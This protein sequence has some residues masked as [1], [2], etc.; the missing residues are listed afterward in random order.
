MS[1]VLRYR[2]AAV[3]ILLISLQTSILA[4]GLFHNNR[5]VE[6]QTNRQER[7]SLRAERQLVA[8]AQS[9]ADAIA[10]MQRLTSELKASIER[11][12]RQI[13][14]ADLNRARTMLLDAV[15]D[16]QRR[17]PREFDRAAANDWSTTFR[18]AELQSA[19]RSANAPNTLEIVSAVQS[20]FYSDKEGV[21][22]E[23]FS[24][25][26]TGLRRYQTV[27]RL[28][29]EASYERQLT[30]VC[31][32]IIEYVNIYSEGRNP[33]YF[34]ALSEAITWLDDVS[35]IE[36]RAGRLADLTRIASSGVNVRLHVGSDFVQ[37][38]FMQE[39][40]EELE[41]DEVILG[42]R[43]VGEGTLSGMSSAELVNSPN[44]AVIR[45]LVDANVETFTD[46]SQ[47]MVN[48]KNHT[49]GTLR[50]EKQILFT[51][52][53]ISTT[54]ARARANF[55]ARLSDVRINAGPLVRLV[56]RSQID[57]RREDSQDEAARR[58]ERRMASQMNE[59]IDPNIAQL[60]NRYQKI[61]DALVK[62]GLFPRVWNLSSTPE[63]I[64]WSMQ[65]GNQYQPSAPVPPAAASTNGLAVQVHQSA[66]NNMLA[67]ALA[68]RMID[69]DRFAQRLSEFFDEVPAFLQRQSDETP[70][71]VSFGE[72][73]P[74]DVIF[75][76]DKI[77]VIVRLNDIQVMD[78]AGRSFN[79][80]V[81][82]QI[83]LEQ[84]DG[85]TLVVLEQTEAD[86]FPA[87]YTPGSGVS[88]SVAQ[89]AIRSYIQRRL[90]ALPKRHEAKALDLG[91][92]WAE[93][94]QLI[95][96]FASAQNGWLTLVW[97]W[98]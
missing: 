55:N 88:L 81:E 60:N 73:A 38:G 42:S 71:K 57:T 10:Q 8:S 46:G 33:L 4:Q 16:L 15:N 48:V 82:Y 44:R 20:V 58:A 23:T 28:V 24:G 61:R 18:L 59:Q 27:A 52:D 11:D 94:G 31:D 97:S 43:V 22:G 93:K 9:P 70:A 17:L 95:P 25:L 67:I 3:V 49:T 40:V 79:I 45:V 84:R 1:Y 19:L 30:N 50:G 74:V 39:I 53:S 12:S 51:A 56:A 21:N 2:L 32:N 29:G 90:G 80:T 7:Q 75:I 68:D 78:N 64:N 96:K 63:H 26:R 14:D 98:E 47:R 35:F 54:P 65:L 34:V 87:G 76:D 69:E 89:T 92:E 41:I 83:K 72:R 36:P 62:N 66:L 85:Q 5:R 91:G 77:R 86:A 6:R 37:A 13:T